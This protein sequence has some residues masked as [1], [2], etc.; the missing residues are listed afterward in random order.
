MRLPR[1]ARSCDS[2]ELASVLRAE[3]AENSGDLPIQDLC[4]GGGY[5]KLDDFTVDS[6]AA[7]RE[8]L[9]VRLTLFFSET[10]PAG[11]ST[12]VDSRVAVVELEID[13]RSGEAH[14]RHDA[15]S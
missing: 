11:C 3:I 6:V 10:S 4:E 7:S 8:R 13:R 12:R 1:S 9:S 15:P 5:P 14:V 2:P